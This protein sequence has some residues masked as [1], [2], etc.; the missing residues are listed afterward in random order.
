MVNTV[1][2]DNLVKRSSQIV[3]WYGNWDDGTGDFVSPNNNQQMWLKWSESFSTMGNSNRIPMITWQPWAKPYSKTNNAYP[4]NR[5]ASGAFDD[6]IKKAA[7]GL[8][9]Y[10]KMVYLRPIHEFDGDWYPW[11]N[12]NTQPADFINAWKRIRG[13]FDSVGANN[14]K[15]VWCPNHSNSQSVD[16]TK[17]FP[18]DKYI[19]FACLDVYSEK[20]SVSFADSVGK[21]ANPPFP[22]QRITQVTKKPII[23]AEFGVKPGK[24]GSSP[25][26]A[27]WYKQMALDLPTK[28]PQIKAIV[29]FNKYEYSLTGDTATAN[30]IASIFG[31]CGSTSANGLVNANALDGYHSSA[32][33]QLSSF[34]LLVL[35]LCSL[36]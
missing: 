17:F 11:G 5:V 33:V 29:Q 24:A 22:Y 32:S 36:L 27:D 18:G 35:I 16:Q 31:N 12:Q 8:K 19:D 30:T 34:V 20:P 9:S 10:G 26:R 4:M 13:I 14:V 28:L 25:S 2:L 15:F 3:H 21:Y 6:Y 23:I 7:G 1:A